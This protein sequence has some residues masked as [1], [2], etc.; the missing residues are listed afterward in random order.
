MR[1]TILLVAAAF[2]LPVTAGAA[3]APSEQG[4][5]AFS[6]FKALDTDMDRTVSRAELLRHG[7]Q[8]AADAL[9]TLLDADGDGSLALKEVEAAGGGGRL[10]RFQAYDVDNDGVVVRREFPN[11][12]DPR[13]FTALDRDGDSL[14][15]LRDI[16]VD[17]AGWR[18]SRPSVAQPAQ[19]RPAREEEP[20]ICWVPN[21][22]EADDWLIEVPVVASGQGCRTIP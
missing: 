15:E 16:R 22:A 4:R 17:F 8:G 7:R 11:F 19:E 18:R 1:T 2:A 10:A 5:A 20:P 3:L 12:L 21:F 14:L 9:F 6:R 13:L